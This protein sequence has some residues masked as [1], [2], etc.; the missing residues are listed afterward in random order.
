MKET[1]IHICN[2]DRPTELYGLLLSLLEQTYKDF[3][4]LVLDDGSG[5]PITRYYFINYIIQRLKL[6]GHNVE[7]IRNEKGTGVSKARQALVDY[8]MKH[9]KEKYICRIDDDSVCDKYFLEKLHEGIKEGYDLM[10]CVVPLFVGPDIKRETKFVKPII[11]EC[12]LDANGKLIMNYDDCGQLFTS[13]EVIPTHHFRS[14]CLYKREIHEAGIDY[15]TRLGK[16]GFREEQF[17]S[18]KSILKGFKLGIHT[19][20]ICWHL[21]CPS[22]GERSTGNQTSNNQEIFEETTKRMFEEHGDFI[23]DYNV[24]HGLLEKEYTENQLKSRSNLI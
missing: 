16:H 23:H 12:R 21:N 8:T 22:G 17:F 4:I 14:S 6:N 5:T 9:G 1:I 20:A 11:G 15:E 3:N 19:G 24:K 10:G 7:F 2:K 13:E 18:F